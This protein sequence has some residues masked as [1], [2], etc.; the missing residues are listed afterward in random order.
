MLSV[1]VKAFEFGPANSQIEWRLASTMVP[2]EVGT[3]ESS[4]HP[5]MPLH[6]RII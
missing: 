1:L 6:V 5:S 2:Y 4:N 3:G